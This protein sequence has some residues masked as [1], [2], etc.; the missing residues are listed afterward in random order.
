MTF[1]AACH[2]SLAHSSNSDCRRSSVRASSREALLGTAERVS[3]ARP[4]P[5][6]PLKPVVSSIGEWGQR[7]ARDIRPDLDPGWLVWAMHRRL[8][9]AAMPLGRTVI[10]IEFVDA[11]AKQRRFWLVHCDGNVDVC[12]KD[13]ATARRYAYPPGCAFLLKCGEEFAR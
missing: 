12:L 9:T 2:A 5:D 11:P 7:W 13:P 3:I 1:G 6:W 10:E 4:K 8:N